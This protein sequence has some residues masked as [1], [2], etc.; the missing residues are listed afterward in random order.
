MSLS[1]QF[2]GINDTEIL[3]SLHFTNRFLKLVFLNK[4][5]QVRNTIC[6]AERLDIMSINLPIY[7]ALFLQH[8]RNLIWKYIKFL[9]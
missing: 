2:I 8:G 6:A 9:C 3:Y 4:L 5:H 7:D 1:T